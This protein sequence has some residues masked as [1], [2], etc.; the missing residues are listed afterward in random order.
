MRLNHSMLK[1]ANIKVRIPKYMTYFKCISSECE[2]T[3]CTTWNIEVDKDTYYHLKTLK[4]NDNVQ[5]FFRINKGGENSE[6]RYASIN[7]LQNGNCPFLD[8]QKLC[9]I[10]LNFNE[11]HLPIACR[12]YPRVSNLINGFYEKSATVSCPEAAR[13]ILLDPHAMDIIEKVEDFNAT[14][15]ISMDLDQSD[16]EIVSF[17]K[18]SY[19]DLR[20]FMFELIKNRSCSISERLYI[21]GVFCN[22]L[23]TLTNSDE[24]LGL[25]SQFKSGINQGKF[26]V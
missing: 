3:C 21:L 15:T 8:N 6:F 16:F 19:S 11:N 5:N 4:F 9:S 14:K 10:Q 17:I 22:E 13:L 25:I 2:D 24:L 26:I 12:T 20:S 7:M 23:S 1:S 18:T